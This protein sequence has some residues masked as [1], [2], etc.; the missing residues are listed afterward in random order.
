MNGGFTENSCWKGPLE[1]PWSSPCVRKL[2]TPWVLEDIVRPGQSHLADGSTSSCRLEIV[3]KQKTKQNPNPSHYLIIFWYL[4]LSNL[5]NWLYI[6]IRK[7][8]LSKEP[9]L[10]FNSR[11]PLSIYCLMQ[12][13]LKSLWK[14]LLVS[15]IIPISLFNRLVCIYMKAL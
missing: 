10:I 9:V 1:V 8:S 6:T 11:T 3:A 15:R 14:F 12:L 5:K 4:L 7:I 13:F 2:S